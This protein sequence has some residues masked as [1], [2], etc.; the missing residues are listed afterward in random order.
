MLN[1]RSSNGL[2]DRSTL[3]LERAREAAACWHAGVPMP[4]FS[5]FAE[6]YAGAAAEHETHGPAVA[7]PALQDVRPGE[8][9]RALRRWRRL[10]LH[11]QAFACWIGGA[12]RRLWQRMR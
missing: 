9:D 4:R 11:M 10:N 3:S 2:M 6:S 1:R 8:H 5:R 12:L 7:M